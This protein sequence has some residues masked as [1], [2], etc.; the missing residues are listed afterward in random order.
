MFISL[1]IFIILVRDNICLDFPYFRA[2]DVQLLPQWKLAVKS[3]SSDMLLNFTLRQLKHSC[4]FAYKI[5]V[6]VC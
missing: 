4:R 3:F 1:E 6:T 5:T 2:I